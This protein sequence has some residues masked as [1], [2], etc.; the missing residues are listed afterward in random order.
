MW[1]TLNVKENRRYPSCA[2]TIRIHRLQ[3]HKCD[4]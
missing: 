2:I 1:K 3:G 4:H